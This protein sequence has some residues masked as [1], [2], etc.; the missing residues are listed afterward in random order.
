MNP[1]KSYERMSSTQNLMK[2]MNFF[3]PGSLQ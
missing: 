2:P 3:V 1:I